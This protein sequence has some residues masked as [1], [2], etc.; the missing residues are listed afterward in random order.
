[1][2]NAGLS[3]CDEDV[4]PQWQWWNADKHKF[5]R[6]SSACSPKFNYFHFF[7]NKLDQQKE[8]QQRSPGI[9]IWP[10]VDLDSNLIRI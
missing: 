8:G 3:L 5:G 2:R 10:A 4:S 9:D 1:M 6:Q 7:L